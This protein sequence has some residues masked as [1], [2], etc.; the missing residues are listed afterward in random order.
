MVRKERIG[1]D[2]VQVKASEEGVTVTVRIYNAKD[3]EAV[4]TKAAGYEGKAIRTAQ[5]K[6][7][8][9]YTKIKF[10]DGY[11][12]TKGDIIEIIGVNET[13][14]AYTNPYAKVLGQ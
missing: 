3:L 6:V 14:G 11:T 2:F 9:K 7:G 1:K 10:T 8:K 4:R 13:T 12:L 5:A